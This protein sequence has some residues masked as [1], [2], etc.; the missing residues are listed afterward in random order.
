MA[1]VEDLRVARYYAKR[2]R[3]EMAVVTDWDDANNWQ[4]TLIPVTTSKRA[5]IAHKMARNF[6]QE[7]HYDGPPYTKH[8][9]GVQGRNVFL[10]RSRRT[11]TFNPIVCG[12]LEVRQAQIPV[13]AWAWLHPFERGNSEETWKLAWAEV[14]GMYPDLAVQKP[15]SKTMAGFLDRHAPETPR[16]VIA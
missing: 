12:A 2:D 9:F 8:D 14:N 16:V 3:I 5:K 15:L 11:M 1:D 4:P 10:L 13:L 6:H 7:M